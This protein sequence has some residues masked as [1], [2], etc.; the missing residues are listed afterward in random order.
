MERFQILSLAH[1]V[2]QM[3]AMVGNN[4][5]PEC[6]T[7]YLELFKDINEHGSFWW[8]EIFC[9]DSNYELAERSSAI[10]GTLATIQRS[11]GDL[12]GAQQT[13]QVYSK[14][15]YLYQGMCDRCTVQDQKDCCEM[16][17]YKHDLVVSNT[18]HE[19]QVKAKCL[20]HFRRAVEYELKHDICFEDQNLAFAVPH[21]LGANNPK[22]SPLTIPKFRD[23]PDSK[24]WKSL[25]TAL[26]VAESGN[27]D[28][29]PTHP[30]CLG[31][32]QIEPTKGQ[33]QKCAACNTALYC[34]V[35]CQRKHW[36]VH[37][38]ECQNNANDKS[39]SSK[40]S[41]APPKA[42]ISNDNASKTMNSKVD[43]SEIDLQQLAKMLA[44]NY[45]TTV[46]SHTKHPIPKACV[47]S[48]QPRLVE[49]I[50]Q[51]LVTKC[52]H[53]N[54]SLGFRDGIHDPIFLQELDK[55]FVQQPGYEDLKPFLKSHETWLDAHRKLLCSPST[56]EVR[57]K[58]EH[59]EKRAKYMLDTVAKSLL[60]ADPDFYVTKAQRKKASAAYVD[61]MKE[62]MLTH[63]EYNSY[64]GVLLLLSEDPDGFRDKTNALIAEWFAP[65]Q[66]ED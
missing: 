53:L 1:T 63:P 23:I 35:G 9:S 62:F 65:E 64:Q 45:A 40:N 59:L 34:S 6:E 22:Y 20:P 56:T 36:K 25:M 47:E 51:L 14:V 17:I 55:F 29:L 18:Y 11:R 12:Q 30:H 61:F 66:Q 4:M 13:I 26:Q 31:C 27:V 24:L 16:L 8:D 38:P 60:Y 10:L 52:P 3:G 50:K 57:V 39:S 2:F 28:I 19:L 54:C 46:L 37:K 15:I 42:N 58:Q 49:R 7:R 48:C 44:Q 21:M 43:V 5:T 41:K 32:D 33:F